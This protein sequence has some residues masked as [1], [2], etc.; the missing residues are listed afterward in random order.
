MAAATSRRAAFALGIAFHPMIPSSRLFFQ[1]NRRLPLPAAGVQCGLLFGM[2]LHTAPPVGATLPQEP[3]PSKS[4]GAVES[5]EKWLALPGESRAPLADQGFRTTPLAKADAERAAALLWKEHAESIRQKRSAELKAKLI[6]IGERQLKF[7]TV[8]F[9]QKEKA[10]SGG[11]SLFISLHGGGGAPAE[12]NDSQWRNQVKLANGYS[13]SEGIYVAPRAP[14]NS[15]DLWHQAHIDPLFERL[16]EDFIAIE[17]VNPNRVYLLGYSAGGD[18]VYQL[19]PR[20]ADRW[21]AA[22]M[23]A[24]H[25]NDASPLGLR[26]IGFA[27]QVGARDGAYNRNKVAAEWGRRLDQLQ[28]A[29]S[30]GYAHF[31]EVHEGKGHWMEL[32]DRKAI[33]W[34]EKFSRNP[35]PEKV[36]WH[37]DDVTHSR[38]YW[39]ATPE[40]RAGDEIVA[41]RQ[42]QTITLTAPEGRPLSVRLNDSMVALDQP[43]TVVR[44]EKTVFTG[45]LPR[46]IGT[47]SK[48]LKELGDP[49]LVF[50]AEIELPAGTPP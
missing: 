46:T 32:A 22:A 36:V 7:E 23:M 10:P 35:L 4:G 2:L 49:A 20:M 15:W 31:T 16:I 41:R 18:G 40:P 26:N 47:I 45:L 5:L 43:V 27:I 25:P 14:T 1:S 37:Q 34:M 8:E 9:G 24:G 28:Q 21:A 38:F 33:P 30:A 3:A 6:E 12:V 39:L 11:R 19:A 29:D 13:P 50:C 44:N 48:T 42:Q 17:N